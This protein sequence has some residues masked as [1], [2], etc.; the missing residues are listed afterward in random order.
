MSAALP[1]TGSTGSSHHLSR[2]PEE[3]SAIPLCCAL[4]RVLGPP[5]CPLCSPDCSLLDLG[6]VSPGLAGWWEVTP[7][8]RVQVGTLS[9]R[10]P[11][12]GQSQLGQCSRL[13]GVPVLPRPCPLW[14][15]WSHGR[16]LWPL[17][18]GHA[19]LSLAPQLLWGLRV[20]VV[21]PGKGVP[22][23][24]YLPTWSRGYF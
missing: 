6:P 8:E 19:L 22:G 14:S 12:C 11:G 20:G 23:L 4:L 24:P 15:S 3:P 17:S 13:Q 1:G 21:S 18:S 9:R 10:I 5:S 16:L 2:F 7:R